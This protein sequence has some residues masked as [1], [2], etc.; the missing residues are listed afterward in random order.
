MK[1]KNYKNKYKMLSKDETFWYHGECNSYKNFLGYLKI[2][3]NKNEDYLSNKHLLNKN[4]LCLDS[5]LCDIFGTNLFLGDLIFILNGNPCVNKAFPFIL[6]FSNYFYLESFN[7][8]FPDITI[9][10]SLLK[11]LI[12]IGDIQTTPVNFYK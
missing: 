4:T 1:L 9:D 5:G 11:H 7:E 3:I 10:D 6:R 2:K 12:K 8:Y